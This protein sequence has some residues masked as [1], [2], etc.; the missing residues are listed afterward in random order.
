MKKHWIALITLLAVLLLAG[1]QQRTVIPADSLQD[2]KTETTSSFSGSKTETTESESESSEKT[3]QS[4]ASI[5]EEPPIAETSATKKEHSENNS[6]PTES[7]STVTTPE[8]KDDTQTK[9]GEAPQKE[10]EPVPEPAKP[11]E[12]VSESKPEIE[13]TP[14]LTKE[15]EPTP[16]PAPEPKSIYD[17]EFDVEAI[18]QE[19]IAVGTGMGLTHTG[20]MTPDTASW[21]NPV[22]AS[23][24]FQGSG[25]ERSLKDYVRSMPDII[26]MYGGT[27]IQYF[28][29]YVE[30][31]GGGSCRFYFLY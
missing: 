31:L 25:L 3:E 24:N 27:T 19:L 23:Q 22:T 16:P 18:R 9:P 4:E 30:P 7:K 5:T 6:T 13:A 11:A 20:D 28:T 15:P 12:T 26:T 1:C 8:K 29:I 17:Y 21:S 14:E 2:T 10:P